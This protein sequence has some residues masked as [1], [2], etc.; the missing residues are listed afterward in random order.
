[1]V[2]VVFCL[3]STPEINTGYMS[4]KYVEGSSSVSGLCGGYC[5]YP[6]TTG[7]SLLREICTPQG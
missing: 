4:N 5:A 6:M 7:F 3:T 2:P 1:M